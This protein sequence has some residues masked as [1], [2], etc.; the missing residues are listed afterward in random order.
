MNSWILTLW[1]SLL[2]GA[3]DRDWSELRARLDELI[4][5]DLEERLHA[6]AAAGEW[7]TRVL[8]EGLSDK[9][10]Q[11]FAINDAGVVVGS[12]VSSSGDHAFVWKKQTGIMDLN[13]ASSAA[14][15][16]VLFEA[17]SINDKGQIIAMGKNSNEGSMGNMLA[18][19]EHEDCAPAPPTSFLL[20][21][22]AAK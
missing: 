4:S 17:H 5:P 7:E 18:S 19:S 1:A 3:Q 22:T 16:V 2:L 13:D 14:L 6:R 15:G 10:S 21:P 11:A 8:L 12:F 9:V 20:T